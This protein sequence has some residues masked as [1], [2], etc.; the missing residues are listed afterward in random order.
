MRPTPTKPIL[1]LDA[2]CIGFL[3]RY[4]QNKRLRWK[5]QS[6]VLPIAFPFAAIRASPPLESVVVLPADREHA[7]VATL[8]LA[9]AGLWALTIIGYLLGPETA[10]RE[11][12]TFDL[13]RKPV[14]SAEHKATA[15]GT[16]E[17]LTSIK[18]CAKKCIGSH[19]L[20]RQ[21]RT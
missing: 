9:T 14:L 10:G 12:E 2:M 13:E 16:R 20:Q 18:S 4:S 5:S 21:R 1:V 19:G 17:R 7:G 11:L 8:F 6:G 3:S 15:H